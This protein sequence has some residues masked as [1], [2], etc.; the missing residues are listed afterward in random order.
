MTGHAM[1]SRKAAMKWDEDVYGLEYDLDLFN[2]VAVDDFNM[3]AMENKSLNVFNSRLILA[4]TER[5]TDVDYTAIEGVVAH[6]YFYNWTGNRVTYRNWFQLS[7][8][9][10]LTVYRDQEFSPD[11]NCRAVARIGDVALL[12][13]AQF[14][15][16]ALPMTH[17]VPPSSYIKMDNFYTVTVYQEGVEVVR[18]DSRAHVDLYLRRTHE[19]VIPQV[20]T[21]YSSHTRSANEGTLI[22]LVVELVGKDGKDIPLWS[23]YDGSVLI[24]LADDDDNAVATT[25]LRLEKAEQNFTFLDIP[26][27]P[28]PSLLRN[29]SPPVRLS[30][31]LTDDDLVL[32]LARLQ[33]L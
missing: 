10:G 6:E 16:D 26:E 24:D 1:E 3:G 27:R 9:E 20:Q 11:M 12:R 23:L 31:D 29:F 33:R 2:I 28:V 5:A 17:P 21:A 30:H 32:L 7:L 8:K 13:M 15:E 4:T 18:M 22:L 19:E 14:P 25:V